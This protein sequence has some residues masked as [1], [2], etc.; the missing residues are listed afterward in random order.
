VA[1]STLLGLPGRSAALAAELLP[2]ASGRG[3]IAAAETGADAMVAAA[4]LR[5]GD[6]AASA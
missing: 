1:R 6:D 4:T 5:G 2:E 3:T